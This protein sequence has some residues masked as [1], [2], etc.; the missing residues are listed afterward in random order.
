MLDGRV[1]GASQVEYKPFGKPP[2]KREIQHKWHQF[3]TSATCATCVHIPAAPPAWQRSLPGRAT[4]PAL[5]PHQAAEPPQSPGS[6]LYGLYVLYLTRQ[7][8]AG[9]CAK[10]WGPRGLYKIVQVEVACD[11]QGGLAVRLVQGQRLIPLK[12]ATPLA[13]SAGAG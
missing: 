10:G 9:A 5:K 8:P 12:V 6:L 13:Q 7:L 1:L 3:N 4:C 11:E 2:L